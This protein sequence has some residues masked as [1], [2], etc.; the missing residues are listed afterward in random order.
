MTIK[1]LGAQIELTQMP[2]EDHRT[3]F[4]RIEEVFTDKALVKHKEQES[5]VRMQEFLRGY[6]ELLKR[7]FVVKQIDQQL[8]VDIAGSAV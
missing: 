1:L 8:K 6:K 5:T 4:P 3:H 7:L 2:G